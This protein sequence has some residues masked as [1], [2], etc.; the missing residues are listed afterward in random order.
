MDGTGAS[1]TV[2]TDPDLIGSQPQK[3]S[4][5][6]SG[7]PGVLGGGQFAGLLKGLV[8]GGGGAAEGAGAAEGIG[9]LAEEALPLIAGL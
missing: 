3:Q 2:G 1:R 4:G 7:L 9:G 6:G 8:G 5:G